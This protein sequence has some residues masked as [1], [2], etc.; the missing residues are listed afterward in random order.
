MYQIQKLRMAR[1]SLT[2]EQIANLIGINFDLDDSDSDSTFEPDNTS[3]SNSICVSED[4]RRDDM[5][6]RC[7]SDDGE[8]GEVLGRRLGKQGWATAPLS[9]FEYPPQ[10]FPYCPPCF[11]LLL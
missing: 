1:K 2:R 6:H 4:E 5:E 7:A 11:L 10:A 3:E 9:L 8:Y